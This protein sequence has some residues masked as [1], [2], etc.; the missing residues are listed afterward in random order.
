M[1][2]DASLRLREDIAIEDPW[3]FVDWYDRN[4]AFGPTYYG[5]WPTPASPDEV[6][7]SDLGWGVLLVGRPSGR[8]AHSLLCHGPVDIS[9]VP[10]APL[11][12]LDDHG[13]RQI[14]DAIYSIVELKGFASSLAT[15]IIH[16]K[17]RASVPLLD[18]RAIYG[19]LLRADWAPGDNPRGGTVSSRD[20]IA[21]ALAAVRWA[22]ALPD[23]RKVWETL[24]K[25]YPYRSRIELFDICWWTLVR[26]P[27]DCGPG[28]WHLADQDSPDVVV[29]S[30][31]G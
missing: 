17:R 6:S 23:N 1:P 28:H 29:A 8:A 9:G 7:L 3:S 2:P 30:D 25:S 24:E 22:V 5:D 11:H 21:T 26:A 15:K 10:T 13:C 18:N 27:T 4:V 12:E 20:R 14:V 31:I 19:T 16:P